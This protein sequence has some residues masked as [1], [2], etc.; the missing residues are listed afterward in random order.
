MLGSSGWV[1]SSGSL[2]YTNV[3]IIEE[4]APIIA[5]KL[6]ALL[7]KSSLLLPCSKEKDGK[8]KEAPKRPRSLMSKTALSNSEN[9]QALQNLVKEEEES[10]RPDTLLM[11]SMEMQGLDKVEFG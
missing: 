5:L 10:K 11:K 9:D 3:R 1:K 7:P 8:G 2:K 4:V 6:Q